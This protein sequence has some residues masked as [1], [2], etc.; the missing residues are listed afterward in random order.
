MIV[1]S[2]ANSTIA[3]AAS[4][5]VHLAAASNG[6]L[7]PVANAISKQVPPV[8]KARAEKSVAMANVYYPEAM[9]MAYKKSYA[10]LSVVMGK[11]HGR[12]SLIEVMTRIEIAA[13]IPGSATPSGIEGD[14]ASDQTRDALPSE[15]SAIK[16]NSRTDN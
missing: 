4:N 10:V 15:R 11:E 7:M 2:V 5:G 16:A 14:V 3:E 13:F 12:I 1:A 8:A 9:I 6:P